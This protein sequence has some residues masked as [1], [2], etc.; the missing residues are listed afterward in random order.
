MEGVRILAEQII[1]KENLIAE[2][3]F[4]LNVGAA[5][6]IGI[7]ILT[8]FFT[9]IKHGDFT[10]ISPLIIFIFIGLFIASSFLAIKFYEDWQHKEIDYIE[11]KVILED[12]VQMNDFLRYYEI[13]KQDGEIY[14]VREKREDESE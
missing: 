2:S 8:F 5:I 13:L 14:I 12:A 6:V 4:G 10:F 7:V 9:A 3:L 11:K 1:Y